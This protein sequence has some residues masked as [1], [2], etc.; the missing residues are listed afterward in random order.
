M[1]AR[2]LRYKMNSKTC[3]LTGSTAYPRWAPALGAWELPLQAMAF[4]A[5]SNLVFMR[6]LF[7]FFLSDDFGMIA[8]VVEDPLAFT[9][10]ET[11]G[12][13]LRPLAVLSF[14]LD[15]AL[16][17]L[18]PVGY[19]LT[20]A[21]LH[22]LCA[23]LASVLSWEMLR[24]FVDD[25]R[26]R[27][28]LATLTGIVFLVLPCHS[29]SVAWISGRTD[30]LATVFG[31][32]SA[33]SFLAYLRTPRFAQAILCW[34]LFSLALLSK[35]SV[36]TLPLLFLLLA[37]ASPTPS[38]SKRSIAMGLGGCVAVLAGY[39]MARHVALGTIIGGYGAHGH[40]AIDLPGIADRLVRHTWRAVAPPIGFDA[41]P[42]VQAHWK[43]VLLVLAVCGG[44]LCAVGVVHK[45]VRKSV[46]PVGL[47]LACYL[48]MLIP[49]FTLSVSTVSTQGE[50]FLY[51]P[52]LFA[53][54]GLVVAI[55]GLTTP[56]RARIVLVVVYALASGLFLLRQVE[57]W[58]SAGALSERIAKQVSEHTA[59]SDAKSV[60]LNVPA[61]LGGAYVFQNGLPE[62]VSLLSPVPF[63]QAPEVASAH[64][65]QSESEAVNVTWNAENRE[66]DVTLTDPRSNFVRLF[67]GT[68]QGPARVREDGY[69]FRLEREGD[70]LFYYSAGEV[71][72]WLP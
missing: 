65:V 8:R 3:E 72:K 41:G 70:A 50:R 59:A 31:L 56:A 60:V 21:A 36:L 16:W 58:R 68:G 46:L 32:G 63:R 25:A 20:N 23:F 45:P 69:S 44:A 62:A 5:V 13:F 43:W 71:L 55:A 40:L 35:E 53:A 6:V 34:T 64:G 52:S 22:G 48:V 37:V 15:H 30:L 18:D 17:G 19:H 29:E 51:L 66:V 9:W 12:G 11:H 27:R 4:V 33:L 49:V 47:A 1:Q 10:G 54:W 14:G 42:Y 28:R 39:L 7:A 67:D 57:T 38:Q 61:D 26:H 2:R 24:T